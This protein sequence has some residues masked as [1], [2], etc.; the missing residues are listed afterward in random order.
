MESDTL[1]L[2]N[3]EIAH[4]LFRIASLLE[5]MDDNE[6]RVRAYRRAAIGVLLLRRQV[7]EYVMEHRDPPLPGVGERIMV[8][9]HELVNTGHMGVYETF[10]D[11]LGEPLA[12]LL[13]LRGVGPKTAI[14][15]VRELGVNSLAELGEAARTGRIQT[16]RGFGPRKEAQIAEQV[17]T[18]LGGAA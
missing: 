7:A 9:I 18:L 1:L 17:E 13:A 3:D 10:L 11:E 5:M 12:S 16:L 2:T 15:L 4:V 8:R 6:Y 14:R